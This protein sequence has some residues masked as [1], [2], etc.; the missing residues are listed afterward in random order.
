VLAEEGERREA[1]G[2]ARRA[3]SHFRDLGAARKADETRQLLSSLS[4]TAR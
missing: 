1:T 2:L 4:G 3:L